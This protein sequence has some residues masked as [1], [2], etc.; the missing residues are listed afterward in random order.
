MDFTNG[1][2]GYWCQTIP[3]TLPSWLDFA[4]CLFEFAE[5]IDCLFGGFYCVD[6]VDKEIGGIILI[7]EEFGL[8]VIIHNLVGFIFARV[9]AEAC[10]ELVGLVDAHAIVEGTRA[11]AVVLH[12]HFEGLA[13]FALGENGLERFDDLLG[14]AVEGLGGAEP[15]EPQVFGNL[16]TGII[17]SLG[18]VPIFEKIRNFFCTWFGSP[19]I[20]FRFVFGFVFGFIPV[21]EGFIF[22]VGARE[23]ALGVVDVFLCGFL[24]IDRGDVKGAFIL[25]ERDDCID[26]SNLVFDNIEADNIVKVI[27]G[28]EAV[29]IGAIL[30]ADLIN[31]GIGVLCVF[32]F[33]DIVDF[34]CDELGCFGTLVV[35]VWIVA[36]LNATVH[37]REP[38]YGIELCDF[39]F[40]CHG[41][42][43]FDCFYVYNIPN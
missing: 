3:P 39:G 43:P 4:V 24:A 23:L 2:C 12:A 32:V 18:F 27:V 16:P 30:G 20:R 17:V 29:A 31:L 42:P 19:L 10:H 9:D 5:A 28:R 33:D 6:E 40:L 38:C 13:V 37:A 1:V 26:R 21:F 8:A 22:L 41:W 36:C 14:L 35:D 25:V 7:G 11:G 15:I 34:V